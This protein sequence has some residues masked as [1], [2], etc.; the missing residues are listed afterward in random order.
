MLPAQRQSLQRNVF[1]S[2]SPKAAAEIEVSPRLNERVV[3]NRKLVTV[4][5]AERN[6]KMNYSTSPPSQ[7]RLHLKQNKKM[8]PSASRDS[9]ERS[10]VSLLRQS[11]DHSSSQTNSILPRN[12]LKSINAGE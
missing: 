3:V 2:V 9:L 6:A 8:L 12:L 4:E 11:A 10:R 7:S 1:G 5:E